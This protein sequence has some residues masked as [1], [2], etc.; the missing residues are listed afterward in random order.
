VLYSLVRFCLA[1]SLLPVTTTPDAIT[2]VVVDASGRPLPRVHVRLIARDAAASASTFTDLD[3]TFQLPV[4]SLDGCRIEASLTGFQPSSLEC[5]TDAALRVT[6]NLAPLAESV[7]VSATRTEAPAGQVA[8]SLT[9][10][11]S[12]QIEQRQS[13]PVADLLRSAPGAMVVRVG[14]LGTVT[15]LFVRGGES[16]YTKVLLDGIPL[17]EPGGAFNFSNV[18][19]ENLERIEF[20][21]G[22]NSA[23]FGSDAMTGV[24]QLFTKRGNTAHPDG[25]VQ[26]E[27]GS[28]S[29]ARGSIAIAGQ[30]GA[31]DY[32]AEIA[33]FSTDNQ[34]ANDAFRNLTFSVTGGVRLGRGVE[35]RTVGRVERGRTG[36]PGQTAF[37]R[38]DLDAFFRRH[39]AVWGL[40]LDQ[41]RGRLHQRAAY[42][43]AVT[44]QASTNRVL[45]PPYTPSF[46]G[47]VA[48]FQFSDFAYDSH[49][50]LRRH[51][52][53]Y[54]AD[55]TL[56]SAHAGTHVETA[57]ADWEGERA[58]LSD[59]LNE[60][61]TSASRNN[62]GL[63]LQHQALWSAVFLTG[64]MRIEHNDSF[65]AAVVPRGT[66]AWYVRRSNGLV[67][68][69]QVHASAGRGIKE[70]TVLQSFSLSPSFL[71][72]PDLLPERSRTVE[73]G[74]EQ[75][76]ARDRAKIDVTWFDNRYRDII[77][78]RTT[79]FNPFR[80]GYFNVGLTRA[81]GAE[82][83]GD[84]ALVSG[85]RFRAGY[86][87]LDSKILQSTSPSSAVFRAGQWAFRRPR[88]SGYI[89]VS[90]MAAHASAALTGS[91]VGRRVDSDFSALVPALLSN[92]GRVTWDAR[93]QAGL[94]RRFSLTLAVDNLTNAHYMEPL[95][96][97]ALGRAFRAGVRA[98]F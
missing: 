86:T 71:G 57:V 93:G 40:T 90:W 29:T 19:S 27:A 35:I 87:F 13:P 83:T 3:G 89:D 28:F 10:F 74:L 37:G 11:D 91:M 36:V 34:V 96:Y 16:N 20:L 63:T 5:R 80:A 45:D 44:H 49:T 24:V 18:T 8:S 15:S 12:T 82:L 51:H 94:T 1:V 68:A 14:G 26:I 73:A 48:P 65:G 42:G 4:A 72:N 25:R 98:R 61:S 81:R 95:G 21:R 47:H 9:V 66:A 53:S 22:A 52:A 85:V 55:W 32:S 76:L 23:L 97:P 41:L 77:S 39:D 67:G 33:Q 60:T 38:P 31:A 70:P 64:S 88:H 50:D 6:L 79:S 78:T 43:L 54:Q 84:L 75:R 30:A 59:V 17:N 58:R 62:A 92:D 56:S 2:G 7:V 69:T 46:D